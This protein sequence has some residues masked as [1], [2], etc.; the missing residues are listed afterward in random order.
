MSIGN[1][2]VFER[3]YGVRHIVTPGGDTITAVS[4]PDWEGFAHALDRINQQGA[5]G[6]IMSPELITSTDVDL[7]VLSERQELIEDRIAEAK[8]LTR[9][10]PKSTL[11]LGSVAFDQTVEKPRNAVL[12]LQDGNEVGRTYKQNPIGKYEREF[13]HDTTGP[14]DI[15]RPA[16]NILNIICSDLVSPPPI[17]AEVDTLLVNA[18]W[19]TPVGYPGIA[20]SPDHRHLE[21]I[22]YITDDLFEQNTSLSAIIMTDRAPESNSMAGPFNFIATR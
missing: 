4:Q 12:F 3:S 2:I 17:D 7:S 22:Q 5:G 13:L 21:F 16:P 6:F 8:K 10:L 11:L 9:Q 1:S 19:G 14:N 18:C 20:A 15:V